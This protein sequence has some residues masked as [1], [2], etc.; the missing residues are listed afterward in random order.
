MRSERGVA[1]CG[2]D[3]PIRHRRIPRYGRTPAAPV[4]GS[5]VVVLMMAMAV[6]FLLLLPLVLLVPR[7]R[8]GSP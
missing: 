4:A 6:P 7:P 1:T 5:A 2:V 3:A 8:G